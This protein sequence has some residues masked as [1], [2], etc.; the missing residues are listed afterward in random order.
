MEA[1][2]LTW[3]QGFPR[4]P[5]RLTSG[6][7]TSLAKALSNVRD[8]VRKFGVDSSKPTSALVISSNVTLG[9][10]NPPDPAVAV[11]FAW[12]GLQVCIPVDRYARVEHNLQAIHLILEAR[13]TEL[14][15]GGLA[16]VRATFT[17][18]AAL[19]APGQI[20]GSWRKVLDMSSEE[21]RL[22]VAETQYK[23]LRSRYHPDKPTGNPDMFNLVQKAWEQA[24][25]ELGNPA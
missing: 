25:I 14:R 7:K 18:L 16:I 6:F 4:V 21:A 5:K 24:Q 12:D 1:Y 15:H 20:H 3:P 17:G 9:Q 22:T 8:S 19:P 11:W 2:P 10:D 23:A 13:R